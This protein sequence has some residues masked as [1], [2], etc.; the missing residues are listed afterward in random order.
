MKNFLSRVNAPQY[1]AD[2]LARNLSL[3]NDQAEIAHYG[4]QLVWSLLLNVMFIGFVAIVTETMFQAVVGGLTVAIVRLFAG[5]A[6]SSSPWRCALVGAVVLG[7]IGRLAI[8]LAVYATPDLP[9]LMILSTITVLVAVWRLAPVDS[10]AKPITD[11][12]HRRNLRR[13]AMAAVILIGLL[14]LVLEF[15]HD[16]L[17]SSLAVA[18]ALCLLWQAFSLTGTGHRLLGKLDQILSLSGKEGVKC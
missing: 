5:G 3:N 17:T 13:G 15:R 4:L 11:P 7:V 1:L 2:V 8:F 9:S 10:P 18:M 12:R 6:H 14:E 16:G